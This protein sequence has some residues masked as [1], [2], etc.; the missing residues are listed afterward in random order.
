MG[1]GTI[2]YKAIPKH[3]KLYG[4]KVF[5]LRPIHGFGDEYYFCLRPS[6]EDGYLFDLEG[7]FSM[8]ESSFRV[9]KKE[10][11]DGDY[12]NVKYIYYEE[13]VEDMSPEQRAMIMKWAVDSRS[14]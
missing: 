6:R 2:G 7:E 5:H 4:D 10:L 14:L 9:I 8:G 11:L 3:L 13:D 1:K 12:K